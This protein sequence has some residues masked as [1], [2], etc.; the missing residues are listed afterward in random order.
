MVEKHEH[1]MHEALIEARKAYKLDEVPVGAIIVKNDIIIARAH[2]LKET[3]N[4]ATA[5][6]EILAI[7]MAEE[8][9][10]VWRLTGC[11]IYVTLEP[12]AMCAGAIINSRLNDLYF[13]A[14]DPKAGC[15]GSVLN[16][17]ENGLFNHNAF[18]LGGILEADCS[19]ILSEYFK[20]KRLK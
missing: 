15:C 19:K 17:T 2:N 14:Y 5:H 8:A 1:Y 18:V 7:K 3:K 11:S 12:C 6:A 13:G 4:D 10:G 16:V 20:E 9:L